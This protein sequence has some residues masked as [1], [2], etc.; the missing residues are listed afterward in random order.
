MTK[1]SVECQGCGSMV[2]DDYARV[3]G[4]NSNTVHGCPECSRVNG[5]SER[6]TADASD[7]GRNYMTDWSDQAQRN[8]EVQSDD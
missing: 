3:F 8:R 2:S 4:D 6:E 7:R 1:C 5:T